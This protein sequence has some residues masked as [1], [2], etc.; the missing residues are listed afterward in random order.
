M[1]L[2]QVA[3][4]FVFLKLA[5]KALNTDWVLTKFA[6]TLYFWTRFL[7][8]TVVSLLSNHILKEL[9]I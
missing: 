4:L 1:L 6:L 9:R 7:V 5:T 3:N 8:L 2:R